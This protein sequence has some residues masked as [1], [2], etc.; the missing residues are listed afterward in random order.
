MEQNSA[1]DFPNSIY[2]LLPHFVLSSG[3][4]QRNTIFCLSNI[5]PSQIFHLTD[6]GCNVL[7]NI[8][9]KT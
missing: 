9:A 8:Y 3:I 4:L 7:P 2:L 1:F 6:S 5:V